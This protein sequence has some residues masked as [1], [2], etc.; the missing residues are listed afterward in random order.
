[1]IAMLGSLILKAVIGTAWE[2]AVGRFT[3]SKIFG[4][5]VMVLG[6]VVLYLGVTKGLPAMVVAHDLRVS[7]QAEA[8][9]AT[10]FQLKMEKARAAALE[11]AIAKQKETLS[12]RD[13]DLEV[14]RVVLED[15]EKEKRNARE[16]SPNGSTV[17]VAPD[18]PWLRPRR[19]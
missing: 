1:M 13:A 18:D 3:A 16:A 17:V 5:L 6:A 4:P 15:L 8:R 10:E 14:L 19:R 2:G 7:R 9:A 11:E 12:A